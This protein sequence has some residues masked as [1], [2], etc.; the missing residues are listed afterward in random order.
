MAIE[1]HQRRCADDADSESLEVALRQL[2]LMES[3]LQRF[4]TLGRT[5]PLPHEEVALDALV[6]EVVELVGPLCRHANIE[7]GFRKCAEPPTV[8]GQ[9]EDLR[10]LLVNLI[11]NAIEAAG[12]GAGVPP[13][14]LVELERTSDGQAEICVKDTGPGPSESTRDEIFEPFVTDKPDGT[15]LGLAVARQIVQ[16]HQG[17]IRWERRDGMTV[18]MVELPSHES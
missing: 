7:I 9:P 14:V 5:G 1:I 2:R 11:L 18:F 4:L 13:R 15:G 16:A 8:H 6:A 17:T 12:R 3:Y 10:Q